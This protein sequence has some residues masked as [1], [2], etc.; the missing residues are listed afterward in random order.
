[1]DHEFLSDGLVGDLSHHSVYSL[2]PKLIQTRIGL[3]L[4]EGHLNSIHDRLEFADV[5]GHEGHVDRL[6]I[7]LLLHVESFLLKGVGQF[8]ATK[9]LAYEGDDGGVGLSEE[10]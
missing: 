3:Y 4:F 7:R 8:I 5:A 9:V 10:L 1:M 6:G 2:A